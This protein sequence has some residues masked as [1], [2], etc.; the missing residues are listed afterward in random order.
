MISRN[1]SRR[2]ER[3]EKAHDI[4]TERKV[5]RIVIVDSDGSMRD[6]PTISNGSAQ[7]RLVGFQRTVPALRNRHR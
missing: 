5:W 4:V 6:G 2:L 3:F 1:L 7:A